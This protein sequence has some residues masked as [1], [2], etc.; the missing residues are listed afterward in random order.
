MPAKIV[1]DGHQHNTHMSKR[2]VTFKCSRA[3]KVRLTEVCVWTVNRL[4]QTCEAHA[5]N[6]QKHLTVSLTFFFKSSGKK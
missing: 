3:F 1:L 2:E 6:K 5:Q 4:H